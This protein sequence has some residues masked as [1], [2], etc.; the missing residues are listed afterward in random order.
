MKD[1]SNP[2]S[3]KLRNFGL[4]LGGGVAGLF[5]IVL[6]LLLG[7]RIPLWPWI[8]GGAFAAWALLAPN[9]LRPVFRSWMEFGEAMSFIMSRIILGAVFYLVVLPTGLLLKVRGRD[10]MRRKAEPGAVSYRVTSRMH[11]PKQMEKPF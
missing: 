5:G 4:M 2:N 10:P 6:P 1:I 7:S 8:V 11:L 9:T 3:K